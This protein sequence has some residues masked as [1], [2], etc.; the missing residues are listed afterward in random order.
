MQNV[1]KVPLWTAAVLHHGSVRRH[2]PTTVETGAWANA[3]RRQ[4]PTVLFACLPR[5]LG[6]QVSRYLGTYLSKQ[7]G[8]VCRYLPGNE[9]DTWVEPNR[10]RQKRGNGWLLNVWLGSE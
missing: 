2:V 1:S 3:R 10:S 8:I 9:V 6:R 5:Y 7:V 4:G